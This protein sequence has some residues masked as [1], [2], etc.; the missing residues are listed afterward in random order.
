MLR[1][2]GAA[3]HE[4]C[5]AA[6]GLKCFTLRRN[7]PVSVVKLFVQRT[8][9]PIDHM[10]W[11][12]KRDAGTL[13]CTTAR[14]RQTTHVP[15][16][17]LHHLRSGLLRAIRMHC[18]YVEFASKYLCICCIYGIRTP[19]RHVLA[20]RPATSVANSK[21]EIFRRRLSAY[22]VKPNV[23]VGNATSARARQGLQD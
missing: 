10:S 7:T 5:H 2:K 16:G 18:L 15:G 21:P 3:S 20:T 11:R 6:N 9:G 12:S 8:V 13:S 14:H 4:P 22:S 19:S 23:A 1:S 17:R